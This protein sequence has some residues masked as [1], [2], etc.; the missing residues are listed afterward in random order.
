[1]VC[2][3]VGFWLVEVGIFKLG[4]R[5]CRGGDGSGRGGVRIGGGYGVC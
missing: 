2:S 1:M 4:E 5:F 3:G